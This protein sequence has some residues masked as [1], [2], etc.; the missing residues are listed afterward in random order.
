[1]KKLY[2]LLS[3]LVSLSLNPILAQSLVSGRVVSALDGVALPGAGLQLMNK[4][5]TAKT[6]NNGEFKLEGFV[7]P[8]T[9]MV[10]FIGFQ[11]FKLPLNNVSS[12]T[13]LEIRLQPNP[14]MMQEVVVSTGYQQLPKERST[15][16]FTQLSQARLEEQVSVNILDRLEA[17]TN[18]LTV[19]RS[20]NENG[21]F[22]IRG[23][24]TIRGPKDP[25]IVVDNFPY[26]GDLGNI[27]PNDVESITVLKDA[28]AASIWGTR[29]GNGVIV[30]TT[31][32]GHFKQPLKISFN[33][34]STVL[35]APDL[36]YLSLMSAADYIGVE[37]ML[38]DKG[39]Y[40]SMINAS[41]KPVVS[42]AV[43]LML[44]NTNG[45]LSNADLEQKLKILGSYDVRDDF[46]RYIY[47]RGVNQQYAL[48][49]SGGQEKNAWYLS[50]GY[51]HNQSQIGAT[52]NRYNLRVKQQLKLMG[53][54]VA[55]LNLGYTQS[56]NESGRQAYGSITNNGTVLYPYSRLAGADG[57]ALP[58]VKSF[59][60]SY[61]NTLNNPALLPW[62]YVPLK[63]NGLN[64]TT[65]DLQDVTAGIGLQ[66][67]FFKGFNLSVRHQYQNQSTGTQSLKDAD[68]YAA[69]SLI[70]QF[71][72]LNT[73][74]SPVYVIPRGGILDDQQ[75]YV[76]SVQSRGQLNFNKGWG[77]SRVDALSGAELRK[78]VVKSNNDRLY[79]YDSE[80]LTFGLV[81]HT[82]T[83]PLL[84]GGGQSFIED[85]RSVTEKDSRFV[86]LFVNAA[87]TFDERYIFSVSGRRDASN[88]FGVKT[89][90]KWNP[91]GSF[92]AAWN[93]SNENFYKI[94]ALP[95]LKFR[96]TYGLSGNVDLAQ[97][98][99]TTISYASN[100][101]FTLSPRA[102]FDQYANPELKWE[103]A[104]IWNSGID[105]RSQG[106]RIT[107]SIEFYHK[108]GKNLFGLSPIDYTSGIGLTVIK[109]V[110]SMEG[111]G[112]DI[113]LNSLNIDKHFK[114][115]TQLNFSTYH[116]KV[117]D[118]Y[119]DAVRG[120][121]FTGSQPLI[122]GLVGKPVYSVFSF[123]SARLDPLT[124]NP[125]G[126]LNGMPSEDYNQIYQNATVADLIYQGSALP[127]TFGSIGNTF[128]YGPVALT[129]RLAFK[130]GY[131]F[132]RE[133]IS[134]TSLFS[135]GLGNGDFSDRWQH[136]GDEKITSVPSL[137]YPSNSQRDAFY[138]GSE[139]L[140]EKGDH[141]RLQY[142]TG[143]YTIPEKLSRH[144]GMQKLKIYI[145]INNLG[146]L[147][148]SNSSGI[149]PDYE[150][151]R[152]ALLPPR[153]VAFGFRAD[154]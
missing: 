14:N 53:N 61:L 1:M 37:K 52:Y 82:K 7:F 118:Y 50:A 122:S 133:G 70:N 62:D 146:I 6:D 130:M 138:Q 77:K 41:N 67:D 80:L 4:K 25:L 8:D 76:T 125:R 34:N 119:L 11:S 113:Q 63:E 44:Q 64:R 152:T 28:A 69:R 22:S 15:G 31:K 90:D 117:T 131:Y 120:A 124:G 81:D 3:L 104:A 72:Q 148:R 142:I 54:F 45:Q 121:S 36:S 149:D 35:D 56:N 29:A 100:S 74:P 5:I 26:E 2:F 115:E 68:S 17:I 12:L 58:I 46:N 10:T 79:G 132:K 106:N 110:A 94:R 47:N 140:S 153:T 85:N 127:T 114:W 145:N 101:P 40:N 75:G 60:Q 123:K 39:F 48:G 83:Y 95:Y 30:I 21:R 23:L 116:D 65:T 89:N 92:G 88:L 139:E 102:V 154:F 93:I 19:D 24:S 16:S 78:T 111:K 20:T 108:K 97:A 134:Y 91:L 71:T 135:S 129:F 86:S 96:L 143:D 27:N 13:G 51:D 150:F 144:M 98:A 55:D 99:V 59:R 128:S 33:A 66:Y 42:P 136:P 73:T 43:E 49:V 103:T 38:Y 9:L 105:F 151:N 147:W 18:G 109:N 87:Y 84:I 32:K 137:I 126:Y 57:E 107:G 112:L 141:L